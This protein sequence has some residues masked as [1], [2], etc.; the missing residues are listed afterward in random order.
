MRRRA[1]LATAGTALTGFSGCL[2]ESRVPGS[3][4]VVSVSFD[5]LQ[6]GLV[7]LT[8]PDSIGVTGDAGQYLVL[9]VAAESETTPSTDQ[10]AFAFDGHQYDPLPFDRVRSKP[11]RL[12]GDERDRKL[13]FFGLPETGTAG[14]AKL[15][16]EGGEWT[17]DGALRERL[18]D[19]L[20]SLDVSVS[21]PEAVA[22][23]ESATVAVTVTNE[24]SVDGRYVAGL[25]RSGP[26]VAYTPL[27]RFSFG[28]PSGETITERHMERPWN[29]MTEDRFGDEEPDCAYHLDWHDGE[30]SGEV[31]AVY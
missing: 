12:R 31:R 4:S 13:L 16:W 21:I 8:T 29:R 3:D 25:N 24:G 6:P 14:D 15:T 9:S 20:P 11:W 7:T 18:E 27:K 28:V 23:G 19:S 30:K 22:D 26:R 5:A 2:S 10:F 17:P 1:L